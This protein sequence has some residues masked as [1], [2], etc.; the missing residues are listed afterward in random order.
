M[1]PIFVE[2]LVA[3]RSARGQALLGEQHARL[4][5]L[6]VAHQHGRALGIDVEMDAGLAQGSAD[7]A[8]VL[9]GEARIDRLELRA[10]EVVAAQA[11]GGE[12][13]EADQPHRGKAPA[14][15]REQARP[16]PFQ[17]LPPDHPRPREVS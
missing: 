10:G 11:H 16:K 12:H 8:H 13:G 9:G 3:G 14:A 2:Q 1:E 5:G 6:P 17:L 4:G 15:E 7:A